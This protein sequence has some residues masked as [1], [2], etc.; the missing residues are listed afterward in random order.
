MDGR[1]RALLAVLGAACVGAVALPGDGIGL[2]VVLVAVALAAVAAPRVR[3]AWN[4]VWLVAAVLLASV[5]VVRDAA[6]VVLPCLTGATLLGSLS[7]AGGRSWASLLR[8]ALVV[9]ATTP[10]G[11]AV[12]GRLARAALPQAAPGR[13]ATVARGAA[14][15]AVLVTVFGAL[16]ASADAAFAQLADDA[17]PTSWD[18]SPGRLV[19]FV[20]VLAVAAAVVSATRAEPAV[21]TPRRTLSGAEWHAGL[22]ALTALFAAFV[23]V[24]LA[25]LFARHDHILQTRG[26]TYADYA[27]QGF[28]QLLLVA[29]LVL[30]LAGAALRYGPGGR[31]LAVRILLGALFLLTAVIL[32]SALH[33][34]DLYEEAYGATRLRLAAQW[35]VLVVGMLLAVVLV[36]LARGRFGGLPRALVLACAAALAGLAAANPDRLI[37]ERSLAVGAP[38]AAYLRSLSAD[39]A[40]ALPEHLRPAPPAADGWTAL[41]LARSRARDL[42]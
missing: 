14:L 28:G 35:A 3:G 26:L 1:T 39:A 12:A 5:A 10:V 25:V 33:R 23:A 24:Q 34:L 17:L 27:H 4:V 30:A 29:A 9:P 7:V 22:A 32:A 38:D 6:W 36:A 31:R 41:N 18:I 21:P 42:R 11:V 40:P 16:F 8:G 37:A 13:V 20:A 19:A 2:G 15:A